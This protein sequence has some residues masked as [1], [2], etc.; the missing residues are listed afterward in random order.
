MVHASPAKALAPSRSSQQKIN[1]LT[2]ARTEEA[3]FGWTLE[4]S[5]RNCV[6]D[7]VEYETI[8]AMT[9]SRPGKANLEKIMFRSVV[10]A[11][12]SVLAATK[13]REYSQVVVS[14]LG[15]AKAPL[16]MH[17]GIPERIRLLVFS[18]VDAKAA[19]HLVPIWA[20]SSVFDELSSVTNEDC[21]AVYHAWRSKPNTRMTRSKANLKSPL[22]ETSGTTKRDNNTRMPPSSPAKRTH[23]L[24]PPPS[25]PPPKARNTRAEKAANTRAQK[26]AEK[27]AIASAAAAERE[28]T[29]LKQ[30]LQNAELATKQAQ[31]A[32]KASQ[33][34]FQTLE[35]KMH[36][37]KA[38]L[39]RDMERSRDQMRLAMQNQELQFQST[40]RSLSASSSSVMTSSQTEALLQ[41]HFSSTQP[42]QSWTS[43]T[44]AD[45]PP[46]CHPQL[47]PAF[48]PLPSSL[49][50]LSH[51]PFPFA[52]PHPQPSSSQMFP[53]FAPSQLLPSAPSH[54]PLTSSPPHF[55]PSVVPS[56]GSL[57]VDEILLR[58][59][60]REL[61]S[62]QEHAKFEQLQHDLWQLKR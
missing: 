41:R 9:R 58:S 47:P 45:S 20:V 6:V 35:T 42:H 25:P 53:F 29:S 56:A 17:D 49:A 43:Q 12:V 51:F 4:M 19:S 23:P 28:K 31:A 10:M 59:L 5:G 60:R 3:E 24:S 62:V 13:D 26:A 1:D 40:L 8:G 22:P 21:A 15:K 16:G 39:E 2:L 50:A 52:L 38:A 7:G 57:S 11:A 34:K 48:V 46:P 33:L 54:S 14:Y 55:L 37:D 36:E 32:E 27:K 18:P 44:P 61:H 30:A